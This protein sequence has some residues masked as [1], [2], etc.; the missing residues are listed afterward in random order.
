ML[1]NSQLF[2]FLL[3]FHLY[4]CYIYLEDI[5]N[6]EHLIH[7]QI[8]IRKTTRKKSNKVAIFEVSVTM[9]S[10]RITRKYIEWLIKL[11]RYGMVWN[12]EIWTLGGL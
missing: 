8:T 4:D 11:R 6:T 9:N 1:Y 7:L 12:E 3:P 2:Y 5:N 10:F